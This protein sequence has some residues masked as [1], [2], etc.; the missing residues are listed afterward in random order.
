MNWLTQL[1]PYTKNIKVEP[2]NKSILLLH[3]H[4]KEGTNNYRRL[5]KSIRNENIYGGYKV[6]ATGFCSIYGCL[7]LRSL[8]K[9]LNKMSNVEYAE[10]TFHSLY[11]RY[12]LIVK[13]K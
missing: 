1:K 5:I 10:V 6:E 13:F 2:V 7:V 3:P 12:T 9:H 4:F 11:S 8:V